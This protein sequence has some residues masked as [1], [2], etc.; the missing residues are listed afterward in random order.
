MIDILRPPQRLMN[1]NVAM[2]IAGLALLAVV[3]SACADSLNDPIMTGDEAGKP[4][5]T[6][7]GEALLSP[8]AKCLFLQAT[9]PQTTQEIQALGSA[10]ADVPTTRIRPEI[11]SCDDESA[12]AGFVVTG[13]NEADAGTF[14][15]HVPEGGAVDSYAESCGAEYSSGDP[16]LIN[17]MPN[18][19]DDTYRAT[20]GSVTAESATYW[21]IDDA[22]WP[23]Q[24]DTSCIAPEDMAQVI[25]A[26]NQGWADQ[27][28]GG[29]R[30]KTTQ[31][32][33]LPEGW[34]A[35]GEEGASIRGDAP[36]RD[37]EAGTVWSMYPPFTDDCRS[38]LGFE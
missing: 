28:Y 12:Y 23:Q 11:T 31:Q 16:V 1:R 21:H 4:T 25:E 33:R 30:V 10:L 26:E 15:L 20:E 13:P 35:L 19:C 18:D 9:F 37:M 2:R 24:L 17:D 36:D 8:D 38:K 29:L 3:S 14:T 7:S 32:T 6:T 22:Q 27:Q 34:E 5:D